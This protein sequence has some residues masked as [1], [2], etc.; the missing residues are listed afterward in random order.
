MRSLVWQMN[1]KLR[2][3]ILFAILL[4]CLTFSTHC[5]GNGERLTGALQPNHEL[6]SN[7]L[8]VILCAKSDCYSGKCYCCEGIPGSP[9][10]TELKDCQNHCPICQPHCSKP[11]PLPPTLSLGHRKE[12][13]PASSSP[14][15]S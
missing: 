2:T 11:P 13:L 1:T 15:Y 3:S 7:K 6:R 4:G 9:C 5:E 10:Y 8:R 14:V 12:L